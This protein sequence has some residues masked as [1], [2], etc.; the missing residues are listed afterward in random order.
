MPPPGGNPIN[1]KS[2]NP[3]KNKNKFYLCIKAQHPAML[4]EPSL[5]ASRGGLKGFG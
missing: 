4:P 5:V 2:Q 3:F 1:H